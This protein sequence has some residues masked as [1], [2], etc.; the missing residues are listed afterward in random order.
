MRTLLEALTNSLSSN[1]IGWITSGAWLTAFVMFVRYLA[2]PKMG[3]WCH[4]LDEQE[5]SGRWLF[6]ITNFDPQSIGDQLAFMISA[7]GLKR[8]TTNRSPWFR[9]FRESVG[10]EDRV[11]IVFR[12]FPGEGIA[13]LTAE[14]EAPGFEPV[15]QVTEESRI[16][17]RGFRKLKPWHAI[18][19]TNV[20]QCLLGAVGGI[21]VLFFADERLGLFKDARWNMLWAANVV[22]AVAVTAFVFVLTSPLPGKDTFL[23]YRERDVGIEKWEARAQPGASPS[24]RE[25]RKRSESL[26]A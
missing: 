16:K 23:G 7:P 17:P 12:G 13:N 18:N 10:D 19:L 22:S 20:A 3:Y 5:S 8:V 24:S 21:L 2:R 11:L 6:T 25:S 9:E 4:R 14:T 26:E 1:L 15:I